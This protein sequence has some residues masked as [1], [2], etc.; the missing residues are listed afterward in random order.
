[1]LNSHEFFIKGRSSTIL[2]LFITE[3]EADTDILDNF[4]PCGVI[5][6]GVGRSQL[7]VSTLKWAFET[8]NHV[9]SDY[10]LSLV[11]MT[12][13]DGE[14]MQC[15]STCSTSDCLMECNRAWAACGDCEYSFSVFEFKL[16]HFS[17]SVSY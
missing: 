2:A 9:F 12:K 15:V 13:C 10:D 11:C 17:L 4:K 14:Y 1:M 8:L 5:P 16:F 7:P 6:V 3:N